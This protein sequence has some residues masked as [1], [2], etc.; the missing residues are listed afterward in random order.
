MRPIE[1]PRDDRLDRPV[2]AGLAL[3]LWLLASVIALAMI[4]GAFAAGGTGSGLPLRDLLPLDH[5]LWS[6][7]TA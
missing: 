5:A 4:G 7:F 6:G 3:F 1:S 2:L